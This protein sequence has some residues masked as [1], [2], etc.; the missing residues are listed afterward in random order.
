MLLRTHFVF[1][2]FLGLIALY[3]GLPSIGLICVLFGSLLPDIDTKTSSL[4]RWF[5]F[6]PL[7][8]A[9]SHRGIT[10]S[11]LFLAILSLGFWYFLPLGFEGFVLG[12]GSHLFLDLLTI[13]GIPLFWPITQKFGGFCRTG[14]MFDKIL[15]II[16]SLGCLI[17]GAIIVMS[18][19]S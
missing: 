14:R 7:Q 17:I 12:Y 2:A 15:F 13:K 4:G 19:F 18:Y 9:F 8:V 6:R 11:L 16:S 5:V 3:F 10:H 1:A